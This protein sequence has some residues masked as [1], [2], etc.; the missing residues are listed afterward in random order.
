ML[1][2]TFR[3]L[4]A[5]KLR[6]ALSGF[7]VVLG[8]GFVSGALT[9]T[10]SLGRVFDDLFRSVNQ[11]TA[12]EVR[13]VES[14]DNSGQG[15][16]AEPQRTPVT[17]SLLD[18]LRAVP[19]VA[20]AVGDV[21]GTVAVIDRDGK[22]YDNGGAPDFGANHDANP[23]TTP[24]TLRSGRAPMADDE[25]ALDATTARDVGV[26]PGDR[27]TVVAPVGRLEVRVVGVFGFGDNDNIANAT[28]VTFSQERA[29][30]IL[31][32]PG[33]Y[34]EIRLAAEPGVSDVEL[35]DRVRA[36]LPPRLQALTGDESAAESAKAVK[37]ALG[38]F[39]TFLLVFASVAVF[40]GG[41]LIFNTFTILVTQRQRELAL[42][43]A[44]GASRRQVVGAVL[45]EAVVVGALASAIG[46]GL[47]VLLAVAL[48]AALRAAG[49][50]LPDAD[51]VV[52]PSTVVTCFVVGTLVT[53]VAALV[54]ARRASLV[55]PVAAL[56]DAAVEEPSRRRSAV[57]GCL[58]LLGGSV[59]I[60]RGVDGDL[61]ALGL[62]AL[63][64]F[65][66][67]AGLSPLVARPVARV[68]GAPLARGVP[69]RLGRLNAMRSPRR[70]AAT[71]AALMIGLALVATVS[72]LGAS[73]KASAESF[74]QGALAADLVVQNEQFFQPLPVTVA[75]ELDA[76][77]ETDVVDALRYEAAQVGPDPDD[78]EFVTAAPA[79]SVGRTLR[80][81]PV[82]GQMRL[83][84]DRVLLSD[85]TADDYDVAPGDTLSFTFGRGDT[86]SF[87]V[88]GVYAE[89]QLLGPVLLD[90]S[91]FP[92]LSSEQDGVLLVTAAQ[93]VT[94][95]ELALAV[96]AVAAGY[97]GASV[98]DPQAFA[99]QAT[100]QIDVVI[101]IV[102]V[103]LSLS[104]LIAVLGIVNTMAL[105]VLERTRELG[106]LRAVGLDR[107]R[108]RRM[109][110]VESVVVA[111][112]GAVLGIAVGSAFGVTLQRALVDDG[113]T[114]LRFPVGTLLGYVLLTGVAGVVAA[115][116]PARRAARLDV[117]DA[118]ATT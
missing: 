7:A 44:L 6:L 14:F 103:L 105:A 24:F 48:Q 106:L 69:G 31:S 113:I 49:G 68:I 76:L 55:P 111:I 9:L 29:E 78:V 3:A 35:R 80:L 87:V 70:T 91:V 108:M 43:R 110:R 79:G 36:V 16:P 73:V 26:G 65:L 57:L 72:I 30:E 118:L 17:R 61:K 97:P 100:A 54:P 51:L 11:S 18:T 92:L 38:F 67:V 96:E 4:L 45:L 19:G 63:L 60:A 10:D 46:L 101:V 95:A 62:G 12:V 89:N 81:E 74:I 13:G 116:L 1:R 52:E 77:P 50:P 23:L 66:G 33:E 39:T 21:I 71:S 98:A 59:A 117:L 86:R 104:V 42:L 115:V 99:E 109:V 32:R 37:E 27:L 15:G 102:N 90:D 20:A 94:G 25:I 5:R 85:K 114:E 84:A 47:G 56:R 82:A 22:A 83:A 41:F 53:C 2:H 28:Y 112:F 34:D 64:S 40:V 93:G 107:R 75:S 8:V 88:S 58:L